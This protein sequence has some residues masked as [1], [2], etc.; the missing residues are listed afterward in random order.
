[1]TASGDG[2]DRD[3]LGFLFRAASEEDMCATTVTVTD[4]DALAQA[5]SWATFG[6][7]T[8]KKRFTAMLRMAY[9]VGAG[10]YV[11]RNQLLD[12][13]CFLALGPRG[14]ARALGLDSESP[15]PLIVGGNLSGLRPGSIVAERDRERWVFAQMS[16]ISR[17]DFLSSAQYV[18]GV[19]PCVR[20]RQWRKLMCGLRPQEVPLGELIGSTRGS[21]SQKTAGAFDGGSLGSIRELREAR[22]RWCLEL[23][24]GSI[25]LVQWPSITPMADGFWAPLEEVKLSGDAIKVAEMLREWSVDYASNHNGLV[26]RSAVIAFLA[27]WARGQGESFGLCRADRR[28]HAAAAFRWWS[29]LYLEASQAAEGT[30]LD[31][32]RLTFWDTGRELVESASRRQVEAERQWLVR[33]PQVSRR[34]QVWQR[35]FPSRR[36]LESFRVSGELIAN[37]RAMD[38]IEYRLLCCHPLAVAIKDEVGLSVATGHD[39]GVAIRDVQLDDRTWHQRMRAVTVRFALLFAVAVLLSLRDAGLL[40]WVGTFDLLFWPVLAVGAAF[41]F[42][43]AREALTMSRSTMTA[44]LRANRKEF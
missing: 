3:L 31:Q 30:D 7:R 17:P 12:G 38:P 37:L 8:A 44:N 23:A 16:A 33:V 41:P 34:T 6:P 27:G 19:N 29:Y 39:L 4:F 26:S 21:P 22:S 18:L 25:S 1:M 32:V 24:N 5:R 43:E 9:L 20:G 2:L 15:L 36:A 14:V 40:S 35:L 10:I 28:V 13:V 42:D 11:D